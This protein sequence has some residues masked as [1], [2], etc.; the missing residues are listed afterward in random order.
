MSCLCHRCEMLRG[1]GRCCDGPISGE[2]EEHSMAPA[3][4]TTLMS[5]DHTRYCQPC[6]RNTSVSNR[7]FSTNTF[8]LYIIVL[9][10]QCIINTVTQSDLDIEKPESKSLV[11]TPSP[12]SNRKGKQNR[13]KARG[14]T[15]MSPS[16]SRNTLSKKCF[17]SLCDTE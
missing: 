6:Q 10:V 8:I 17:K 16:C 13:W 2:S 12:K 14:R 7:C 11:P 9:M 4:R 5:S 3:D 15:R 1:A